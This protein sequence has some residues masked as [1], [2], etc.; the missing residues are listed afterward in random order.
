VHPA[1]PRVKFGKL[2]GGNQQKLLA[3]KW[4]DREPLVL[5]VDEPTAG[6]DVGARGVIY[7]KIAEAVQAGASV[8]LIS[9]DAEEIA[10]LAHR[11]LVFHEGR[12]VRELVGPDLTVE[13]VVV[14]CSRT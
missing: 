12:V 14:E 13:R 4:M 7:N 9:S 5:I 10:A 1:D 2:S 8:L 3:A 11:A 6:V